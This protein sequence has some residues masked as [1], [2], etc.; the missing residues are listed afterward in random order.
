[1]VVV[2]VVVVVV[3]VIVVEEVVGGGGVGVVEWVWGSGESCAKG[4][5]GV[6]AIKNLSRGCSTT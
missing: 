4:Q 3:F 1:M 6:G 5:S 2:V